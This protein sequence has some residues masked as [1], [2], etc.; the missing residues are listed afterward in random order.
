MDMS[1]AARMCSLVTQVTLLLRDRQ[2]Y[3]EGATG[4]S[5]MYRNNSATRKSVAKSMQLMQTSKECSAPRDRPFP[6]DTYRFAPGPKAA[7][8]STLE[9]SQSI[10]VR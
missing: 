1:A 7:E 3:H 8:T 9:A 5:R 2:C 6:A 4:E 10:N